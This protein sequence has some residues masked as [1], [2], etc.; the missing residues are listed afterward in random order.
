MDNAKQFIREYIE[1]RGGMEALS[2]DE[3][4]VLVELAERS[5]D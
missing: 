5:G 4:R 2:E 1:T 3:K